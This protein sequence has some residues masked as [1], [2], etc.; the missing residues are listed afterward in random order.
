MNNPKISVIMSVFNNEDCVGKTIDSILS[1]TFNRFEFIIIDD[2]STDKSLQIL[3][4]Y[5]KKDKRIRIAIN[6]K[7]LG[8]TKSLNKGLRLARGEYIARQDADD[9]SLPKRFELQIAFL[10]NNPDVF[11][12]G[13]NAFFSYNDKKFIKGTICGVEN[14]KKMLLKNNH[15]IHSSIMFRNNRKIR[16]REKFYCAQDYDLY[17]N[18]L[19]EGL[20]IDNL[21]TPL[22]CYGLNFEGI[23]SKKRTIQ[24]FFGTKAEE[25]YIQRLESGK[26]QYYEFDPQKEIEIIK[27]NTNSK[28]EEFYKVKFA[29]DLMV[30]LDKKK[31]IKLMYN[32]LKSLPPAYI[33]QKIMIICLPKKLMK[34]Q[35]QVRMKYDLF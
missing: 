33:I 17:L 14:N 19:S 32:N 5:A 13:T 28:K 35:K 7:N 26:D 29:I 16:Y 20:N 18:L 30:Y 10:D 15:M 34:L 9:L 4:A 24:L 6:K 1:Q 25:F 11:L 23:S 8:L 22:V 31:A 12:L 2:C 3:K 27:K 21:N